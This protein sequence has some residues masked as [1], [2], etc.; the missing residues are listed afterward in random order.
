LDTNSETGLYGTTPNLRGSVGADPDLDGVYIERPRH[1][2]SDHQTILARE[3]AIRGIPFGIVPGLIFA[4]RSLELIA[5]V[6]LGLGLF[7]RQATAP[8]PPM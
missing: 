5:G 3:M 2:R 6:A 8:N 1:H 7:P 4:D